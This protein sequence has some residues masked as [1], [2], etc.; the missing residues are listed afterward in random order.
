[1]VRPTH[2]PDPELAEGGKTEVGV[3]GRTRN[4]DVPGIKLFNRDERDGGDVYRL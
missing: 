4:P 3:I 2:H 1:M